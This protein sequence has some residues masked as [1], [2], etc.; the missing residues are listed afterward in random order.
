M[1]R[2]TDYDVVVVG[3]GVAGLSAALGLAGHRR[4]AVVTAGGLTSGSTPW[5]QG[6]IAAAVG[7]DDNPRQHAADT[8]TAGAGMCDP[9]AVGVLT[10]DAP[11]RVA[12]LIADGA[13][14]DRAGDG[15][16]ALTREG[17]HHRHRVLHAGGDASGAE[18]SRALTAALRARAVDVLEHTEARDLTT[19]FS[20]DG[21]Q[22]TGVV[23]RR[24]DRPGADIISAR[25]VVLATGGIG[26]VYRTSSNPP[27]VAGDGL[28]IGLRAGA[29]LVDLEFVQFHPTGLQVATLGQVPLITE[30]LRGEG[31]VLRDADGR[32]IMTGHHPLGDLAP[33]DVVA[34]RIDAVITETG[35]QVGLDA[36]GFGAQLRRRFP[37]AYRNC[38]RHGIDPTT[39]PIPVMPVQH[40]LCGGIRT[41]QW[42][43]S[44][45][46]GLYA[47]GEVAAT[48][49]HGANR[50]ASNSLL[51]GLVFGA[52]VAAR[53]RD[54]LPAPL[55]GTPVDPVVPAVPERA[56]ASIRATMSRY[57]GVRRSAAGLAAAATAL[58][59]LACRDEPASAAATNR[60][61]VAAAIVAA[62]AARQESRGCHWRAD[63]P[64]SSDA[65][66]HR[67]VVRLDDTGRPL[68]V[69]P[70]PLDQSA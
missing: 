56:M 33:R 34:R 5:A 4:V 65:W 53:L 22:V 54:E 38:R 41:D 14:F 19:A 62:A 57:V 58:E 44:D 66:R 69:V 42:G 28:A 46:V 63:H 25:A 20:P 40:F 21:R 32:P 26:G 16:L 59:S 7:A 24:L 48:G 50:L 68:A 13:R 18:V 6:G 39:E 10:G 2:R 23:V 52:R 31:A 49:V 9:A 12:N 1:T 29:A 67:I 17:G 11:A 30:A 27:D 51:E 45:V 37:T 47:V 35:S 60:W 64:T 70:A 55:T 3:S 43:A 61:T 36:T 15:T 8:M